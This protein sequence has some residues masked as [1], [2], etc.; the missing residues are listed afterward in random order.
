MS[1]PTELETLSTIHA[2]PRLTPQRIFLPLALI[3]GTLY[4][5]I[6]PPFQVPDEFQHFY[7]AYQVSEGRLT[8]YRENGSVGGD[9]PTSLK[10]FSDTVSANQPFDPTSKADIHN[11]WATRKIPLQPQSREFF[12]FG[13]VSWHSP[14][15]YFPQAAAMA[16]ARALGFGPFGV[17]YAGR[18]GNLLVWSL[19]IYFSLRLIPILDWTFLL[20]ALT[21]MSLAQAASLSADATVNGICALFVAAVVRCAMTD[22]VLRTSH[23]IGLTIC[24]AAVALAKTA[25]LPLTLLFL[26]IPT[27]R[28]STIRRYWLS[29]TLFLL[30]CL[31]TIIGWSLC[32][33][34][35]GSYTLPDVSPGRQLV[36]MAQH[37]FAMLHMELG[38]LLAVPFFSDIIG[39]LGWH[40]IKLWLPFT[41]L[42]FVVLFWSTRIGGWPDRRLTARQRLVLSLAVIGC[43]L[44]VFSLIYLTFTPVGG[45]SINGLQGRYMTPAMVPFFLI[46]YPSPKPRRGNPGAFIVT[47][48]AA[49]SFYALVV[50][51]RRFYIW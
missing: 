50:L 14:T 41:L 22:G 36:Y 29:F 39:Q 2:F 21:P 44:A 27:T 10:T 42:Y 28:F 16:A 47:F 5:I 23:L 51:V 30:I 17:F 20:L 37:P 34:G 26:L 11:I 45:R 46:F 19:L 12:Y 48:A 9:L 25:Y 40:Q 33:Y 15:N 32:T 13:N 3:L 18:F 24:G 49:F 38:M 6:T 1:S 31:A 43:W 35:S 8:A 7:R 4:A